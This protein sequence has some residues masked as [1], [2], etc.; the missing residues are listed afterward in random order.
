[1]ILHKGEL[2]W[3]ITRILYLDILASEGQIDST[4]H[5]K[6]FMGK[7]YF[8][9]PAVSYI[10]YRLHVPAVLQPMYILSF[11]R[12]S[13]PYAF[14]RMYHSKV[15]TRP[16]AVQ[17]MPQT[18]IGNL[19]KQ[20]AHSFF[21]QYMAQASQSSTI[22]ACLCRKL[23]RHFPDYCYLQLCQGRTQEFMIGV[24]GLILNIL[25]NIWSA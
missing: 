21:H 5:R 18:Y 24:L 12:S 20:N 6:N 11:A 23:C 25:Y 7:L 1:M 22:A 14:E 8:M 3:L 15:Q 13:N 17:R 4:P 9:T 10:M 19:S 2:K 16:L